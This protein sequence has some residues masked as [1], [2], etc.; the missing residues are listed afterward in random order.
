MTDSRFRK[1]RPL[2]FLGQNFLI[3][4]NIAKK[5]VSCIEITTEDT[6]L[7]IGPGY[8]S[9]TKF[10]YGLTDK[11][12]GVELDIK[13][14]NSL[15]EKFN[16]INLINKNFLNFVFPED[17]LKF[18]FKTKN[19]KIIGNIPYNITSQIL[20]KLFENKHFL[21][22]AVIMCQKEVAMR[23]TAKP[24]SKE[25]GILA[26]QT[27]LNAK[28]NLLMNIPPTVFFPKPKVESTVVKL[29]F[30]NPEFIPDYSLFTEILRTAFNKR[31]KTLKNSLSVLFEK[32][33]LTSFFSEF[34][35]SLRPE[36]LSIE[37]FIK[38]HRLIYLK[39]N[40]PPDNI[41]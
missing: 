13:C 16:N 23:L 38:L 18:G 25:Y 3:D 21:Y 29:T 12:I 30:E 17:I 26:V 22:S 15:K 8:G 28:I 39:I 31:R 36:Q 2:K 37:D 35:L 1:Y 33:S 6:I 11:Y 9:L 4:D 14:I 5:I 41:V 27:Q 19:L 10:I 24:N 20:F 7:E 34:D 40:P 32:Y